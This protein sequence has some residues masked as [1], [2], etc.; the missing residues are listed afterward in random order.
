MKTLGEEKEEGMGVT[1]ERREGGKGGRNEVDKEISF[2]RKLATLTA[3]SRHFT[4]FSAGERRDEAGM[5]LL[6]TSV[7]RK[8][9]TKEG[10][11]KSQ[12]LFHP[13]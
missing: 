13:P 1:G 8:T 10:S 4:R 7:Q 5:N 11:L 2:S 6:Q 3:H 9:K 12:A